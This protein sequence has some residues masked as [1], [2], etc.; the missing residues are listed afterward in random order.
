MA[1]YV[2][3]MRRPAT[4]GSVTGR[5]SHLMADTS[6]E[7]LAFVDRLGLSRA[8]IQYPGTAKEH[9]DVTDSV[10]A[11]A[12]RLGAVPVAYGEAGHLTL[13]K[14]RGEVFDLASVRARRQAAELAAPVEGALW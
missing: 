7:L 5:W 8:W 11:A 3:D 14:A 12:L 10:R 6:E 13:A 4:V 9:F 2:D 1:V